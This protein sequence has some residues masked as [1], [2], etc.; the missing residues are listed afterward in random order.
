MEDIELD[1]GAITIDN[2]ILKSEGYRFYEGLL[3]QMNQFKDSPVQV[4]QTDIVHNEAIKHIGHEISNTR[5]L[6]SQST[7]PREFKIE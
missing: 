5:T 3:K 6:V 1:Y 4:I 7:R 2:A